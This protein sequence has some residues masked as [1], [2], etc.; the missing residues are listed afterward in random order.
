MNHQQHQPTGQLRVVSSILSAIRSALSGCHFALCL[1]TLPDLILL[2]TTPIFSQISSK[3]PIPRVSPATPPAP[4]LSVSPSLD[5]LLFYFIILLF[6]TSPFI[7]SSLS[8]SHTRIITHLHCSTASH[9]VSTPQIAAH[10]PSVGRSE[11]EPGEK[12]YGAEKICMPEFDLFHSYKTVA[13]VSLPPPLP[14]SPLDRL[15]IPASR[16]YPTFSHTPIQPI[17]TQAASLPR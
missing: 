15:L 4:H 12:G 2:E 9:A 14:P 7:G 8:P 3:T 17:H 11:S 1:M 13:V 5:S 16:V 6:S 10:H